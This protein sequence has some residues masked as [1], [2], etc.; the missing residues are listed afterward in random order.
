MM[1]TFTRL[2][3]LLLVGIVLLTTDD[4]K[5]QDIH[6]SQFYASPLTLNP[7]MTG[8]VKNHYRAA[9]TYRNQ[10]ASIPVPFST[11][12]GSFDMSL[13]GCNMQNGDHVGI[14]AVVFS[15]RAGGGAYYH[16]H[17]AGSFAYHKALDRDGRYAVSLGVQ[18]G[19]TQKG[20]DFTQLTFEQQIIDFTA[21]PNAP[22]G[23]PINNDQFRYFDLSAGGVFTASVNKNL[24]LYAGGAYYHPT[25]PSESFLLDNLT[26]AEENKLNP[27]LAV[28]GGGE[29]RLSSQLSILPSG[30]Y[31]T[32]SGTST[33]ILG[34]AFGYHFNQSSRYRRGED[35]TAFYIGAWYRLED[36]LVLLAAVDFKNFKIGFSYDITISDLNNAASGQG[37][38]EIS[39][40]FTGKTSECAKRSQ[41]LYCPRF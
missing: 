33:A 21:D 2:A 24:N 35:N 4:V 10:W 14:G 13:L 32:Q 15:D 9:V 23:E 28:H 41:E 27:R 12:V 31:M 37:G 11:I 25:K 1:K 18:A 39:L 38:P 3:W 6:F 16:L 7:A 36:A 22:N 17:G 40:I 34:S 20:V 29:V 26:D 8:N 5:A 19:F 30:L